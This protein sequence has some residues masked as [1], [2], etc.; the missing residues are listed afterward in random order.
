MFEKKNYKIVIFTII[1]VLLLAILLA[2]YFL[3]FISYFLIT[4]SFTFLDL[5]LS[6]ASFI[7]FI[8]FTVLS[9]MLSIISIVVIR[10]KKLNSFIEYAIC[11]SLIAI[12][13]LGLIYFLPSI[14]FHKTYLFYGIKQFVP[15]ITKSLP[16]FFATIKLSEIK[17]EKYK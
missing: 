12:N 10:M 5:P 2:G 15:F 4:D 14:S 7:E 16:I 17:Y 13:L 3:E 8:I 6:T 11:T 9:C 1:Q